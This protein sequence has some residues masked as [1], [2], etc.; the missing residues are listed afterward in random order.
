[1]TTILFA[2]IY[3]QKI[4]IVQITEIVKYFFCNF[5]L[6]IGQRKNKIKNM[7]F[8]MSFPSHIIR[9][10]IIFNTIHNNRKIIDFQKLSTKRKQILFIIMTPK[11]F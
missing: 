4:T 6:L 11:T 10:E 5:V 7:Y 8:V 2:N 3:E 9:L 1:M